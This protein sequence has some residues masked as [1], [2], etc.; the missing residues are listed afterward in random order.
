MGLTNPNFIPS[1]YYT[2]STTDSLCRLQC[3]IIHIDGI[4][5]GKCN[6]SE[7]AMELR[8]SCTNPSMYCFHYT[9]PLLQCNYHNFSSQFTWYMSYLCFF[10]FYSCLCHNCKVCICIHHYSLIGRYLRDNVTYIYGSFSHARV[11][12]IDAVN[13]IYIYIYTY[14]DY[15]SRWI[16]SITFHTRTCETEPLRCKWFIWV[17]HFHTCGYGKLTP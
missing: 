2:L 4:V 8:H 11:W 12:K 1:L 15:S 10:V 14:V 17:V 7:L 9:C 6:S 16:F 5:Q 13:A 3:N